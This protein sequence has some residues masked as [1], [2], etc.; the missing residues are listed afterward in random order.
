MIPTFSRKGSP[1]TPSAWSHAG[2]DT[3]FHAMLVKQKGAGRAEDPFSRGHVVESAVRD[4]DELVGLEGRLVLDD[5]VFG[6]PNAVEA[7]TER[8]QSPDHGGLTQGADDPGHERTEHH[9]VPE[10]RNE[11]EAASG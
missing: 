2:L 7:R 10:A 9:Y 4:D 11:K 1:R 6:N 3:A 5:A 8:R